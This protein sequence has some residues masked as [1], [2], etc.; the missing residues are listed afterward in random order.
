MANSTDDKNFVLALDYAPDDYAQL[1]TNREGRWRTYSEN[2]RA[3][4]IVWT[5]DE[6]GAGFLTGDEDL[7]PGTFDKSTAMLNVFRIMKGQGLGASAA[8]AAIATTPGAVLGEEHVGSLDEAMET[9]RK[10]TNELGI[11]AAVVNDLPSKDVHF[12]AAFD[13]DSEEFIDL[14]K[15]DTTGISVYEN[16]SWHLLPEDDESMD[17]V[18]WI[19]LDPKGVE[20]AEK[21]IQAGEVPSREEMLK[22]SVDN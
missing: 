1:N 5:D 4:G 2:D 3:L 20:A 11:T 18:E 16:E 9:S 10:M 13:A 17:G 21:A 19:T 6:T 14:I 8:Y 12:H 22:F 7:M 15:S